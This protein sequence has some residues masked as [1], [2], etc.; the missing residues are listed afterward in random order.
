LGL[1]IGTDVQAYDPNVT[2]LGNTTTGTGSIVRG[3]SPTLVTPALGTPSAAVLTNATGLPVSTGISATGTPSSS[4]YL[5]GDGTWSTPSGGSGDSVSVNGVAATDANLSDS[6]VAAPAGGQNVKWQKD[7]ST[8]NNVSAYIDYG[9][10]MMDAIRKKPIYYSDF[11]GLSSSNMIDPFSGIAIASGTINAPNAGRVTASHPGQVRLRSSTT[12]NSGYTV[13][14]NTAQILL[15]GGEV[16]ECIWMPEVFTATTTRMGFLDT[17]SSA[18][19]ADGAYIEI[20]SAGVATGKTATANTRSSTGTTYT[21]TVAT[22]YRSRV[23]V[24]AGATSITFEIFNDS[25]TLL[26]TDTLTTNIPTAT[27]RETGAAINTTNSG[28]VAT[29]L[30]HL[31]YQC[32][33]FGNGRALTR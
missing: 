2:L 25:G 23:T 1:V 28:V 4:T 11:A 7:S 14:L 33:A 30:I 29:D 32:V 19:A 17:S 22:W 3:T 21:L 15:G 9:Y 13:A 26:W 18:D 24:N 12:T 5:R 6:V 10:A 20:D 27:G 8:P 31:D 16:F